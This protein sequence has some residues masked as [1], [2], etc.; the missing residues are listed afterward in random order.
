MLAPPMTDTETLLAV[1]IE[2][3]TPIAKAHPRNIASLRIASPWYRFGAATH[4]D[5]DGRS[6]APT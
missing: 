5:A 6:E 2:G 3:S 4:P 1:L